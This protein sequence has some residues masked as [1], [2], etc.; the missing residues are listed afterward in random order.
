[1]LLQ[2]VVHLSHSI[3]TARRSKAE[4]SEVMYCCGIGSYFV[5]FHA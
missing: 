4:L 1:M 2:H 3:R 5:V